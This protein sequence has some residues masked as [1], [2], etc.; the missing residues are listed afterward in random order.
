MDLTPDTIH[1]TLQIN[2]IGEAKDRQANFSNT[3]KIP[4]TPNNVKNFNFLGV[5]GN[6]SLAPYRKLRC[7]YSLNGIP[8][9]NKGYSV[10]NATNSHYEVVVYDGNIDL[11]ERI[12]GKKLNELNFADLNHYLTQAMYQSSLFNTEGYI[13]ALGEFIPRGGFSTIQISEQAPSIFVKTLWDKIFAEAGLGY[14]G[15]FFTEN[16]DFQT[17]VISAAKGYEVQNI[18]LVSTSLGTGDSDIIFKNTQTND[19]QFSI[20][21]VWEFTGGVPMIIPN[22]GQYTLNLNIDYVNEDSYVVVRVMLGEQVISTVIL[23]REEN[24]IQK[25]I[26]FSASQGDVLSIEVKGTYYYDQPQPFPDYKYY[27]N[28]SASSTIELFENTGGQF[29]DFSTFTSKMDQLTFIKDVMQRYGL[30]L[31]PVRNQNTYDFIQFEELL[32]RKETAEDWSNKLS[33]IEEEKYNIQYARN[34]EAV[35]NYPEEIVD[36]LYDG[37]LTID[38]ETAAPSK[39]LFNSPYQI[40]I[41]RS[42]LFKSQPV[43]QNHIWEEKQEDGVTVIALKESPVKIFRIHRTDTSITTRFFN[44]TNTNTVTGAIPFLSLDNMGMQYFLNRYYKAFKSLINRTKQ[45]SAVMNLNEIDIYNLDFFRLKYLK[46]TGKFYY[47]NNVKHSSGKLNK[48]E[49]I[50]L[51]GFSVNLPPTILGVYSQ[52]IGYNNTTNISINNITSQ[53]NPAYFDPEFDAP[54]AI[55]IT[56]GFNPDILIKNGEDIL[57]TQTEILVENWDLKIQDAGNTTAAH[58]AS[59]TFKIKDAGSGEYSEVEGTI[60]ISVNEYVNNPPVANAGPDQNIEIPEDEFNTGVTLNG[61]GS[62]DTTGSIVS[63]SWTILSKPL[64]STAFISDSTLAIAN[65]SVPN[66]DTSWGSYTIEL[67]VT[68][69]FGATDTD[70]VTIQVLQQTL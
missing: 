66:N 49:L 5:S 15:S 45:V 12:K 60:Q 39:T 23:P 2:D 65:L 34:N 22:A 21:D 69:D 56:G 42:T 28:Y 20:T 62:T 13:Y 33:V 55:M 19:P 1:R 35:Y 41:K 14:S 7:D 3:I 44:D 43:Y 32:N 4:K 17:E 63:Y 59:F 50:Q 47:L 29:I 24:N 37:V 31:K 36:Y 58:A 70:T 16:A 10:V 11:A 57:T 38:N 9:I 46:Q 51:N 8:L 40:P 68:D 67:T 64:T 18:A 53:T 48:A 54:A 25:Q 6:N 26:N 30:L 52:T 61:S 27:I